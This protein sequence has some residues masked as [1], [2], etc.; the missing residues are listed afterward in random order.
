MFVF[1]PCSWEKLVRLVGVFISIRFRIGLAKPVVPGLDNIYTSP[2]SSEC[3]AILLA[4]QAH[5]RSIDNWHEFFNVRGQHTIE[6][7]LIPVLQGHQQYVSVELEWLFGVWMGNGPTK[8]SWMCFSLAWS[9]SW[10]FQ[11]SLVTCR[12]GYYASRSSSWHE[13]LGHPEIGNREE[14]GHGFPAVTSPP[15]WTPC[16]VNSTI[17]SLTTCDSCEWIGWNTN[18]HPASVCAGQ[19]SSLG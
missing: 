5:G 14:E 8:V 15:G 4:S 2:W 19:T 1:S 16:P 3:K 9:L 13:A 11:W 6:K 7:L 12:E 17:T 10:M 18:Y